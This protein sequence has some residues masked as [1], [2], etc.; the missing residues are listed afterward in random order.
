[1]FVVV[2]VVTVKV[3][4]GEGVTVVGTTLKQWVVVFVIFFV[5][6]VY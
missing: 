2:I 4:A 5:S 6:F 3:T 1:M